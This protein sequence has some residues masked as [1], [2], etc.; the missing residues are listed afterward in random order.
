M[1][2][3]QQLCRNGQY[4]VNCNKTCGQCANN[5]A[6]NKTNGHCP[7]SCQGAFKPPLCNSVCEDG[8][9]GK[10]CGT[11]GQCGGD[12]VCDTDTGHCTACQSGWSPPLC[13]QECESGR[14]GA[15]CN[16]TCGH[17]SNGCRPDTGMCDDGCHN[18]FDGD[19]CDRCLT[20]LWG[21]ECT[22]P[23]GHCAGDGS[24]DKTTGHCLDGHCVP[25]W[26]GTRCLQ[27][28]PQDNDNTGKDSSYTTLI[29]T[30][31]GVG[32]FLGVA[33]IILAV[34][35]VW[36]RKSRAARSQRN[37]SSPKDSRPGFTETR[38]DEPPPALPLRPS[39][40]KESTHVAEQGTE[41]LSD[42]YDRLDNYELR[43]DDIRP[44]EDLTHPSKDYYNTKPMGT[45]ERKQVTTEYQNTTEGYSYEEIAVSKASGNESQKDTER[46]RKKRI[47]GKEKHIY[48]NA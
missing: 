27:A 38:I 16:A 6:C 17:C 43:E 22:L 48:T 33:I 20:S 13:Q 34:V 42:P 21:A 30:I 3:C 14:Y 25:G 32:V 31:A 26:N 9:Y 37:N 44:Y 18:G 5:D 29:G 23:C 24:C 15:D 28:I 12:E 41:T 19:M 11:C 46:H 39:A 4:G 35:I 40:P 10:D 8:F 45:E 36:L 47:P 1:P 7:G 2:L